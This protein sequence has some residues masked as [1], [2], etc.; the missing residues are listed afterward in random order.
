MHNDARQSSFIYHIMM[1]NESMTSTQIAREYQPKKKSVITGYSYHSGTKRDL[2]VLA[3]SPVSIPKVARKEPLQV[4]IANMEDSRSSTGNIRQR[5][6]DSTLSRHHSWQFSSS[7]D[8]TH[9]QGTRIKLFLGRN[10]PS[11]LQRYKEYKFS[12]KV[13]KPP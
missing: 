5:L 13:E 4:T 3:E 12:G 7:R 2:V 8:R 1:R 11:K 9:S 10:Y 6:K